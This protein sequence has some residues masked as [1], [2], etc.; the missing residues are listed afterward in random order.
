[1]GSSPSRPKVLT[2]AFVRTINGGVPWSGG[3]WG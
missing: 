2:A 1:M 3:L